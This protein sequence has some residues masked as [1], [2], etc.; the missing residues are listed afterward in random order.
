M[1]CVRVRACLGLRTGQKIQ[2]TKILESTDP[3]S[4]GLDEQIVHCKP[5]SEGGRKTDAEVT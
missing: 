2:S 5:G 3:G 4:L 1:S